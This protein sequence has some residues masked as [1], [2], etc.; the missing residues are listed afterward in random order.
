MLN[1][2]RGI[3]RFAL[4]SVELGMV[5]M[6]ILL[7]MMGILPAEPKIYR[8][9]E[10]KPPVLETMANNLIFGMVRWFHRSALMSRIHDFANNC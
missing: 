2:V 3:V 1:I 9:E 5:V 6:E 7:I 10:D 4:H 8:N